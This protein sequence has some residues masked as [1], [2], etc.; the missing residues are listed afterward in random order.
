MTDDANFNVTGLVNIGGAV[1]ERYVFD[2][3]GAVT[4][5]TR[6]GRCSAAARMRGSTCTRVPGGRGE[7][8]GALPQPGLFADIRSVDIYRINY[9]YSDRTVRS[10]TK[11][12]P[13]FVFCAFMCYLM[14]KRAAH[15]A[16]NECVK[17]LAFANGGDS[18]LALATFR[19]SGYDF[20]IV[21]AFVAIP[22]IVLLSALFVVLFKR[23]HPS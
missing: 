10:M 14:A 23:K 8:A 21:I 1:V 12:I 22:S 6:A 3:Y 19:D 11:K 18:Q 7:R 13:L 17:V 2:T 4:C 9:K 20:S 15:C 16:C 5:S